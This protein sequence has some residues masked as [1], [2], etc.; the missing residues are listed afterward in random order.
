[1]ISKECI[2]FVFT[3][4]RYFF[5]RA[6]EPKNM[7]ARKRR[8][9]YLLEEEQLRQKCLEEGKDFEREKLR[10]LPADVAEALDKRKKSKTNPGELNG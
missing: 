8:A 6:K 1:M 4:M 3:I 7:E 10:Q 9:Q 2:L 5:R